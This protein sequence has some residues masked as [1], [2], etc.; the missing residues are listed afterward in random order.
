MKKSIA[1]VLL[2]SL[3][4]SAFS[5]MTSADAATKLT[6]SRSKLSMKV[7]AT[8]TVKANKSVTWKSSNKKIATVKKLTAKKATI[9]AKKAGSCKIKATAGKKTA[10]IRVTIKKTDKVINTP[11]VPVTPSPTSSPDVSLTVSNG[12][13]TVSPTPSATAAGSV[14]TATPKPSNTPSDNAETATPK[15]SVTP[16]E[17]TE[18]TS[19][20]PSVTPTENAETTSPKPSIAPTE[21]IKT[22]SPEPSVTPSDSTETAAPQPSATASGNGISASPMPSATVSAEPVT[23]TAITVSEQGISMTL[24]CYK[25]GGIYYT[26]ENQSEDTI[27]YSFNYSLQ[28]EVNGEWV[29]LVPDRM[30]VVPQAFFPIYVG[31]TIKRSADL[32]NGYNLEPGNYR[33]IEKLYP[34]T[35]D[36][37][38]TLYLPFEVNDAITSYYGV[39]VTLNQAKDDVITYTIENQSGMEISYR[40]AYLEALTYDERL[41]ANLYL[42][43]SGKLANGETKENSV[44]I[45]SLG[46]GQYYY[47]IEITPEKYLEPFIL[48]LP[49]YA[50]VTEP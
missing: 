43:D 10:V 42:D 25:K 13:I 9:T 27:H 17:S 40:Y 3:T 20:Q 36:E 7:G 26:I 18:N 39:T 14:E 38:V 32:A 16:T 47:G 45:L 5:P 8:K 22:A 24:D 21:S 31:E 34:N 2:L 11:K 41:I 6:L 4:L 29:N 48:E 30:V 15:P 50:T 35:W 37:Q 28:K 12:G 23:G 44:S 49:V 33:F 46:T 19:P 1:K